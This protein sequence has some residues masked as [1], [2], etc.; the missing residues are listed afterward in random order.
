MARRSGI[1]SKSYPRWRRILDFI[2]DRDFARC[3]ACGARGQRA[4]ML[5]VPGI[6]FFCSYS[7]Y[8]NFRWVH[9]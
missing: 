4:D 6:G 2:F 5:R 7:E 8:Q 9:R 3:I 1:T